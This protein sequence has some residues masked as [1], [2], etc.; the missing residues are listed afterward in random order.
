VVKANDKEMTHHKL[1]GPT[2]SWQVVKELKEKRAKVFADASALREKTVKEDRDFNADE[3]ATHDKYL[4]DVERYGKQI[5]LEERSLELGD[6]IKETRN[7]VGRDDLDPH[8]GNGIGMPEKD[9]RRYSLLR[10]INLRVN[11]KPLDGVEAEVNAEIAKRSGKEAQGFYV[12]FEY[13]YATERRDVSGLDTSSGTGSVGTR[14]E[15]GYIELLRNKLVVAQAGARVMSGMQGKFA[16]PRQSGG[17]TAYWVGE[18]GAPSASNQTLDQVPFTPK[19]VGAFTDLTRQFIN[20]TSISA[21]ALIRDDLTKVIALAIDAAA[22]NGG[23]SNQPSG[24]LDTISET[25]TDS[26]SLFEA[27]VLLE[28]TVESAN[29]LSGRLSYCMT[30]AV[31]GSMKIT[32]KSSSAVAAG[33]V[34]SNNIVNDYS[35]YSSMQVPVTSVSGGE[36]HPLI[37]GNFDDLVIAFWG[38]GVD[39]LVDPYTHSSSGAVRIVALQDVDIQLRHEES[40]VYTNILIADD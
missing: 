19:T 13:A 23:G 39:I 16:L 15:P 9:F 35:A 6:K 30:P 21:E 18:G 29:A 3:K 7:L 25:S 17:A 28:Q 38:N 20:Q 8:K 31:K 4:A 2:M 27:S 11:N 24:I 12:P 32:P 36:N 1:R 22:L 33:F 26:L 34:W 5:D 40:F 37:F 10:A 14:I